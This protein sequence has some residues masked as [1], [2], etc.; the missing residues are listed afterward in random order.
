[1]AR[2][3]K[4]ADVVEN[5]VRDPEGRAKLQ[6]AIEDGALNKEICKIIGIVPSTFYEWQNDPNKRELMDALKEMKQ[7]EPDEIVSKLYK[8]ALGYEYEEVKTVVDQRTGKKSV[9]VVRKYQPP[10]F[11]AIKTILNLRGTDRYKERENDSADSSQKLES[12]VSSLKDAAKAIGGKK[13]E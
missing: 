8:I 6:H 7:R 1:M 3:D 4:Y 2:P 10:Y 13:D 9:E 11:P 5:F 12:L